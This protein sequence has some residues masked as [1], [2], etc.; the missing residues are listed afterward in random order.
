V[1]RSAPSPPLQLITPTCI[2]VATAI[3]VAVAACRLLLRL[4]MAGTSYDIVVLSSSPPAHDLYAP[5]SPLNGSP[6]SSPRRVAMPA[7]PLLAHSPPVSAQKRAS[8]ASAHGSRKADIPRDAMRGF[9]TVGSLVRSEHFAQQFDDDTVRK[10][11]V[12]SRKGSIEA[13]EDVTATKKKP[14]KRSATAPGEDGDAKP[15]SKPRARKPNAANPET[16][17][18]DPELRLPTPKISPFFATEDA[19]D[20]VEPPKGP[21][22][23]VPKLTKSGKPRKPRAKKE[24]IEGEDVLPKPKKP[25]A[26]KPKSNAKGSGEVQRHGACI[27]SAHFSTHVTI[28]APAIAGSTNANIKLSNIDDASIWEVPKSPQPKKKRLPKQRPKETVKDLDLDEAVSRRRDWTP[29]RDTAAASPFTDSVGKENKAIDADT[30]NG[31]FTHLIS[32]FAYAQGLPAQVAATVA[33]STTGSMAVTKR[34]RVE[35]STEAGHIVTLC[36]V[37]FNIT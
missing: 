10:D 22:D 33:A 30:A 2:H 36:E 31:G 17:T 18:L 16:T 1:L 7:S 20:L 9:A 35:V 11:H 34:R 37:D 12:Q 29:P 15:K 25:R 26:T 6:R 3:L 32:N 13:G 23:D 14:R 8:G 24:K 21:A 19:Q 27:E 4:R 5:S 28:D